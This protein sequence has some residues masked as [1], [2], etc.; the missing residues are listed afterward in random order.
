MAEDVS[1]KAE[2]SKLERVMV[3]GLQTRELPGRYPAYAFA[4]PA[5]FMASPI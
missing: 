5:A 1:A 2:T 3:S 4:K